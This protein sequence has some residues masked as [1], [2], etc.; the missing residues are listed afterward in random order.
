M[1]ILNKIRYFFSLLKN[2]SL[3]EIYFRI[4]SFFIKAKVISRG[5]LAFDVIEILITNKCTLKCKHCVSLIQYYK[6]Q[7]NIHSEQIFRDIDLI[8]S[9]I[10]YTRLLIFIGGETL[11][12]NNLSEYISY[13]VHKYK[14]KFCFI[15]LTTNGT[16][17]PSDEELVN[18]SKW[19]KNVIFSI[20]DYGEMS[21]NIK[22]LKE[23]LRKYNLFFNINHVKWQAWQQLVDGEHK[24]NNYA[25]NCY[26][27]CTT[28]SNT[29]NNGKFYH[30]GFLARGEELHAFPH[31]EA[32]SVNLFTDTARS[33]IIKYK[34]RD[35]APPGCMYCSG[36][37]VDSAVVPTAEQVTAP[38]EY[39][40]Y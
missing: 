37:S 18:I 6:T 27:N 40:T 21:A 38:I 33:N 7:Q 29:V 25:I 32:N 8:F 11:L 31:S 17:V 28:S 35:M 15:L 22:K 34:S 4:K 24:N 13:A 19:R 30:C 1:E 26:K 23:N 39:N 16:I 5:G 20:S 2:G 14:N 10:D 3:R 12:V 9:K 36:H